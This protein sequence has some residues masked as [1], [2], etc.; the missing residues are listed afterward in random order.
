MGT[1][2][3]EKY[4]PEMTGCTIESLRAAVLKVATRPSRFVP[5]EGPKVV[6]A[7]HTLSIVE[8]KKV[9]A[10]IRGMRENSTKV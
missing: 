4:C 10:D 7:E 8:K 3:V 6:S 9:Q 5:R 1:Q 2:S